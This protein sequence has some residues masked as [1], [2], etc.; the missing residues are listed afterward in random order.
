MP[1]FSVTIIVD[2]SE[3]ADAVEAAEMA[4]ED[5]R[6]HFSSI[7]MTVENHDTLEATT[8]IVERGVGVVA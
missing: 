2:E 6:M 4:Y 5:I 7:E 1:A 3:A 8:V